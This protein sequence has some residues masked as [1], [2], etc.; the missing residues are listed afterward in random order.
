MAMSHSTYYIHYVTLVKN[1]LKSSIMGNRHGRP[2]VVNAT[3]EE[4][5]IV[6]D[7]K[8]YRL[9]S[10]ESHSVPTGSLIIDR[11]KT[12][13]TTGAV[14]RIRLDNP[15]YPLVITQDSW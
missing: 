12:K 7:S 11:D 2:K 15:S 1:E 4:I 6:V 13:L 5:V 10:G 3:F 8:T 9:Q 14:Y